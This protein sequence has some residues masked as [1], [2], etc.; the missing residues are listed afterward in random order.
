V[1]RDA[2]LPAAVVRFIPP[3]AGPGPAWTASGRPSCSR[4]RDWR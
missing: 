4:W 2:A 1:T 3:P